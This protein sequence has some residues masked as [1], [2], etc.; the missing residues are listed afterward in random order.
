MVPKLCFS[1]I[2]K[3]GV[4]RALRAPCALR[5][6]RALRAHRLHCALRAHRLHHAGN[7]TYITQVLWTP[8]IECVCVLPLY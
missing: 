2:R 6:P 3:L 7:Y 8:V 4:P 5:A 1:S